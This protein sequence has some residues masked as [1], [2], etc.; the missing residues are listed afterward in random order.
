MHSVNLHFAFASH[1]IAFLRTCAVHASL[2]NRHTGQAAQIAM[3]CVAKRQKLSVP[4]TPAS[5]TPS[6][7]SARRSRCRSWL[8]KPLSAATQPL[9]PPGAPVSAC[10]TKR[11]TVNL[12]QGHSVGGG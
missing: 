7:F 5:L 2:N 3:E 1:W 9:L 10:E 11:C 6:C 8:W 4:Y 12:A